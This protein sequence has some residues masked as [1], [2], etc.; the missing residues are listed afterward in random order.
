VEG[1]STDQEIGEL[2]SREPSSLAPSRDDIW[3]KVPRADQPDPSFDRSESPVDQPDSPS[4]QRP[5]RPGLRHL[6]PLAVVAGAFGL[7]LLG[8]NDHSQPQPEAQPQTPAP[9]RSIGSSPEVS[10]YI[11]QVQRICRRHDRQ[12]AASGMVPIDAIV[13]SET[14][15]TSRM[16]AVPAPPGA[17]VMRQTLLRARH[18]VD[19]VT[20]RAYLQMS[21]S[22]HPS[23]TFQQRIL[24]KV[25]RRVSRM[26]AVFGSFGIHCNA[27]A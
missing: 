1:T 10:A 22:S 17:H 8:H 3:K 9:T 18:N 19:A 20:K 11:A 15:E 5:R 24:P 7:Q 23:V 14:G 16:A 21:R 6:L 2:S 4:P 27:S 13:R 26:Y 12:V 25:R